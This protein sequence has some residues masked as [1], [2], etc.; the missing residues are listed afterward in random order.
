MD[1]SEIKRQRELKLKNGKLKRLLAKAHLDVR[2]LKKRFRHK[3][4]HSCA[5]AHSSCGRIPPETF[6]A[7]LLGAGRAR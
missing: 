1:E 2:A 5:I 3:R 4:R 7:R 6:T